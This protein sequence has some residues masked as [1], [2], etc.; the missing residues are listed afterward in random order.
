M[1]NM[2]SNNFILIGLAVLL[3]VFAIVRVVFLARRIERLNEGLPPDQHFNLIGWWG[4]S[5]KL[6][7]SRRWREI[8]NAEKNK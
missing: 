3:P 2:L 6:R 7:A 5:E 1:R 8:R 4:P